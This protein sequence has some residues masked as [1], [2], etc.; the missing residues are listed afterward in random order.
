MKDNSVYKR[1][2]NACLDLVKRLEPGASIGSEPALARELEVSRTTVRS[3]LAA[4]AADG[5]LQVEGRIKQ[6]LRHPRAAEY[7]PDLETEASSDLIERKFKEWLLTGELKAGSVINSLELARRFDVSTSG[8]R[9]YLNRFSR[10][11]L[12]ERRPNASWVFHGFTQ[13]FALE[14]CDIRELFEMQSIVRFA[15]RIRGEPAR[16]GLLDLK[17]RH[18]DLL[19]R[20]TADF[21]QFAA[22]DEAFHQTI[23]DAS[24]NRFIRE[25]YEIISLIFHYH[26]QWNK[27]D[28]RERNEIAVHEHL[29]IIH[30]L[31]T[32]D[33]RATRKAVAV[34]MSS[35]RNSLLRSIRRQ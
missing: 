2:F 35:A 33:A 12:I 31:E 27:V 1:S 9:E 17:A 13:S 11:G 26:F 30:G 23:N 32:G 21:N 19:G 7:F 15:E 18:L 5:I 25:F 16:R 28:E 24:E 29:A 4:L 3:I 34:H 6:V 22:L 14:L 10:F 20:I 8:I